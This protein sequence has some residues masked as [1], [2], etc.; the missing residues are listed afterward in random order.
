M[1]VEG[2]WELTGEPAAY[3]TVFPERQGAFG[4]IEATPRGLTLVG[5][6]P[7]TDDQA[8]ALAKACLLAVKARRIMGAA[9]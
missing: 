1:N 4:A 3:Y 2:W 7:I 8:L 6:G 9:R 5:V